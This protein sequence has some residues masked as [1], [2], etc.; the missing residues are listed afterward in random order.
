MVAE[1]LDLTKS[2]KVYY[3]AKK[4]AEVVDLGTYPY[5]TI[6]GQ[7]APDAE[8][9]LS[10]IEKLY[11]VAYTIKFMQKAEDLDFKIPKMEGQWWIAGGYE[12]QHLLESTPQDQWHWRLLMRMPISVSEGVF[13]AGVAAAV[14]RDKSLDVTDVQYEVINLGECVQCLHVGSYQEEKP[15]I[16]KIL[17]LMQEQCLKPNGYHTE[18]YLN[19]PRRTAEEKLRTIIR[20]P[21]C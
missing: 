4:K 16:D 1:K 3:T 11:K 9:F 19:D 21:V 5:L 13:E 14:S 12:Q 7:S 15:T 10:A 18:I 8:R 20:H 2:D 17:S 6:S